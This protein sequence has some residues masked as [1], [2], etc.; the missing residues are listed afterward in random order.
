[1][2]FLTGDFGPMFG[3]TLRLALAPGGRR[4]VTVRLSFDTDGAPQLIPTVDSG[5]PG[6]DFTTMHASADLTVWGTVA[7]AALEQAKSCGVAAGASLL[8]EWRALPRREPA[9]PVAEVLSFLH[10][11]SEAVT[12]VLAIEH[13]DR[14]PGL[15]SEI[16]LWFRDIAVRCGVVTLVGLDCAL[17]A[18]PSEAVGPGRDAAILCERQR[19]EW[20]P[21]PSL[22]R[23]DLEAWTG[24][25]HADVIDAL[26]QYGRRNTLVTETLWQRWQR[27]G[28]VRRDDEGRW[29]FSSASADHAAFDVIDRLTADLAGTDW[30]TGDLLDALR[31]ARLEGSVFTAEDVA[32][33]VGC[34]PDA[35]VDVLDALSER[36][37]PLIAEAPP[38][39]SGRLPWRYRATSPLLLL[40]A[41]G[42]TGRDARSAALLLE[43]AMARPDSRS[44]VR[45]LEL[46]RLAS[47]A[48]NDEAVRQ[49]QAEAAASQHIVARVARAR[50]L[51]GLPRSSWVPGDFADVAALLTEVVF[52]AAQAVDE[53]TVEDLAREA[54]AC[55]LGSG[56]TSLHAEA[57]R[58]TGFARFCH[59]RCDD[60]ADH[61][62]QALTINR[63]IG[64]RDGE[65]VSLS[66]IAHC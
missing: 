41:G 62:Q 64:H 45:S 26:V 3:E 44:P 58:A 35:F 14:D 60:A 24:P 4:A 55:A 57:L 18:S 54:T 21:V 36:A 40:L 30:D 20:W 19:A 34:D 39:A 17:P 11:L 23:S 52:D 43:L 28:V 59:G 37:D 10:R 6:A 48:T 38:H 7:E 15:L 66:G 9:V 49:L 1:M 32:R 5:A 42:D 33:T 29:A 47:I 46:A 61:Y 63:A 53:A 16:R 8:N 27:D 25:A 13:A 56:V 65:A 12:L 22:G 2:V 51:I 31:V 50:V